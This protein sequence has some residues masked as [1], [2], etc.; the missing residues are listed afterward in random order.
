MRK[1]PLA[2]QATMAS[3]HAVEYR[4]HIATRERQKWPAAEIERMRQRLDVYEATAR[5]LA[6]FAEH[7]EGIRNLI[8]EKMDG[9]RTAA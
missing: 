8:K 7:E 3:L 2:Q 1:V 5:T 4:A 6:L 9:K